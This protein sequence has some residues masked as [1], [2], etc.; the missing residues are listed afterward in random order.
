MLLSLWASAPASAGG[1]GYNTSLIGSVLAVTGATLIVFQVTIYPS[2]NRRYGTL[3]LLRRLVSL[4]GSMHVRLQPS[5]PW[6]LAG[7]ASDPDLV[8]YSAQFPLSCSCLR[9]HR[10]V[11]CGFSRFCDPEGAS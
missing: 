11:C 3:G 9:T 6:N 2:L 8:C 7:G 10:T 1:L 4:E 5:E